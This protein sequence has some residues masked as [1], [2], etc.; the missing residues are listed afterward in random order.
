MINFEEEKID[1]L[2]RIFIAW[3]FYTN[4]HTTSLIQ[5]LIKGQNGKPFVQRRSDHLC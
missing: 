2:F 5:D 4:V 1:S 3:F